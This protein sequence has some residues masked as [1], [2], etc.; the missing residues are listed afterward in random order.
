MAFMD[1]IESLDWGTYAH[2]R[3]QAQQL[4]QYD[5]FPLFLSFMQAAYYLSSYVGVGVLILL[6]VLL[7][8][9]QG[10]PRSALVTLLIFI[11]ASALLET[12]HLVVP[13]RRPPDAQNWLGADAMLGSYPSAGVFLFT[14]GATLLGLALWKLLRPWQRG[15]YTFIAAL[16][17]VW[18]CMSQFFLALHFLTDVLGGLAGAALFGWIASRYLQKPADRNAP[19]QA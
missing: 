8:L 2:F 14:I 4:Q 7:F 6:A 10:K 11:T 15:L 18:V 3:F 13:R 16:L 1:A 12:I 17:T 9:G 19:N 5:Q